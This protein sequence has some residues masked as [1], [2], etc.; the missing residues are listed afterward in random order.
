M[1]PTNYAWSCL[2]CEQSNPADRTVCSRCHCPAQ[3]NRSQVDSARAAYRHRAGLPPLAP[4][5]VLAVVKTAPLLLIAAAVL[6]LVGGLSLV[7]GGGASMYAFGGLM[8]AL[9]AF[10]ASTHWNDVLALK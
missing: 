1:T 2:A 7:V 3:A 10:C 4:I 5:D 9:A 8:L 6:G